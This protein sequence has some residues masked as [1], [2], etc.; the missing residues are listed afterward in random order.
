[1]LV[2]LLLSLLNRSSAFA[3]TPALDLTDNGI[4]TTLMPGAQY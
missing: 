1:M 4:R 2:S 3:W